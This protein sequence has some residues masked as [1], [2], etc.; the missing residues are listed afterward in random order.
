MSRIRKA[1]FPVAGLGTRF[2][3]RNQGDA[4]GN[5]H[6]RRSAAHPICRGRGARGWHR[7]FHLRHR[8]QQGRDRGS[9]RPA[10]RT[11][12]D[13]TRT[14]Q[15]GGTR[16]SG[17]GPPATGRNQLHPPA[18][19]ARPRPRR[20]VRA[21]DRGTR[22]VRTSPPRRAGAGEKILS[23]ADGE[24]LR[25]ARR[26]SGIYSRSR[27]CRKTARICTASSAWA[28]G[29]AAP[30]RSP[31]WWKKPAK[32]TA[33]SNRIITG[34]YVLQPEIFDFLAKQERGAGGEIQ[35]TD[36][37]IALSKTQPFYGY[38]FDGRTFDCGS[39]IGFL[40]ANGLLCAR[41]SGSCR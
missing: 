36:A 16:S 39:K 9:F 31:A 1:I 27:K 11:R 2:S 18:I 41:A 20:L 40:S 24:R 28:S 17:A 34:R 37:M 5:A 29:M 10:G 33:P 19:A 13:T 3:A 12:N 15:E 14:R 21:R 22:A 35:I 30:S 7:A 6:G 4:E 26:E 8:P 23:R 25:Q 32:G 38:D